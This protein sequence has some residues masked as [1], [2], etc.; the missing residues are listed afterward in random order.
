MWAHVYHEFMSS[1]AKIYLFV[2]RYKFLLNTILQFCL[3]PQT[4]SF[5]WKVA[6][7]FWEGSGFLLGTHYCL[8]LPRKSRRV[9]G[10]FF[11]K[12]TGEDVELWSTVRY[13]TDTGKWAS[14]C[15]S[16]SHWVCLPQQKTTHLVGWYKRNAKDW[17]GHKKW[18]D[19][20]SS[21]FRSQLRYG[22]AALPLLAIDLFSGKRWLTHAVVAGTSLGSFLAMFSFQK[23]QVFPRIS[24]QQSEKI[25]FLRFL[26]FTGQKKKQKW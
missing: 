19:C 18:T 6:A 22:K 20:K 26:L 3:S 7:V 10:F 14:K 23:M 16:S 8:H 21:P 9:E 11:P 2:C 13:L 25:L 15:N 4:Q 24:W 17:L 1:K 5:L 12:Q